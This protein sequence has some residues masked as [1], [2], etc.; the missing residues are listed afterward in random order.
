MN[1][2]PP[3]QT[4]KGW[5][6]EATTELLSAGI[7]SGRLDAELILA[8]TLRKSRTYLHAHPEDELSARHREIA[9]ARLQLR[10]DR[11]PLAYIIGHKE[12]YG[13][14]FRVTPAT[15]IPRPESE[16][17][18]VLLK[19]MAPPLQSLLEKTAL[20]LVDVGTGSGC[21]GI[22]AKLELPELDVALLDISRHALTVAEINA[23]RLEA[24]VRLL[25]SD[26]LQNYPFQAD[27]ILANLPY[28][29]QHWPISPELKHE[30]REA[31]YAPEGG[32]A[33][34]NRLLGEAPAR[35]ASGGLL[36]IEA[37]P[38][39]HAAVTQKAVQNGF[40]LKTSRDFILCF[41][42]G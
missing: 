22:T 18:I 19:E 6:T 28:V 32:L 34:I 29:D 10:L 2:L 41:Q 42:L 23:G 26:L 30:P 25:R 21:L 16:T 15:L 36:F 5:A 39:Q 24:D 14:S 13:R 27:Y 9:D 38:R 11:T 7:S 4:I 33:L 37:D 17:M 35:L 20:K 12:F 31:L 40:R 8:H 3:P 1:L